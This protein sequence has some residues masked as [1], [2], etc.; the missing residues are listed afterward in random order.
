MKQKTINING[1]TIAYQQQNHNQCATVPIIYLHG[2][3]DNS[4]SFKGLIEAQPQH[5]HIAIDLT[6]HGLSQHI[7]PHAYYHFIDGVSQVIQLLRELGFPQYVLVGHSLGGCIAS[8]I[9]ASIPNVISSLILIDALGPLTTKPNASHSHYDNYLTQLARLPRKQPT[10]YQSIDQACKHRALNGDAAAESL[11]QI[12]SRGLQQRA[13]KQ[14]Q[15]R[16]DPKLQ[17]PS[18]L[19]MTEPQVL[20]FLAKIISP[21]LLIRASNG[22]KVN[23][24]AFQKRIE[25]V[26]NINVETLSGG[27]HIHLEKAHECAE[28]INGHI[29]KP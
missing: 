18:P 23:E 10:L 28:L 7:A 12:V 8:L 27:H 11:K 3:L 6:G 20:D 4:N 14:Y 15:W 22:Y 5:H 26:K 1:L 24:D 25:A 13:D 21:T 9:A 17:L 2:W 29:K 19:R 16:H